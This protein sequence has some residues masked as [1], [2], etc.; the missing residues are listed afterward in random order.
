MCVWPLWS[1]RAGD[2]R[3]SPCKVAPFR[4]RG[5]STPLVNLRTRSHRR[6]E[7]INMPYWCGSN[8]RFTQLVIQ[9]MAQNVHPK[10]EAAGFKP[11]FYVHIDPRVCAVR[12]GALAR[13]CPS[14]LE[15]VNS[16][17]PRPRH[18]QAYYTAWLA[19]TRQPLHGARHHPAISS[20]ARQATDPSWAHVRL[21]RSR[22]SCPT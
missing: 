13:S 7:L 18:V 6:F 5:F 12:A 4:W 15:S 21:R 1:A 14:D 2:A 9:R 11:L 3:C 20:V 17:F 22:T 8:Q 16:A 10:V 19:R